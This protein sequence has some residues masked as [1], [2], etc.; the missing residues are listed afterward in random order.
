MSQGILKDNFQVDKELSEK[1]ILW[2]R[3][4]VQIWNNHLGGNATGCNLSIW[5]T[6]LA[7]SLTFSFQSEL[8]LQEQKDSSGP[9]CNWDTAQGHGIAEKGHSVMPCALCKAQ[10][11]LEHPHTLKSALPSSASPAGMRPS[12]VQRPSAP[13]LGSEGFPTGIGSSLHTIWVGLRSNPQ[14]YCG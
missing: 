6:G 8:F 1:Y 7:G 9:E 12:P 4:G 13:E 5:L 11:Q 2:N 3:L 14:E 10:R